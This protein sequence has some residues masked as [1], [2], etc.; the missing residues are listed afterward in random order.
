MKAVFKTDS[1]RGFITATIVPANR[2]R[3]PRFNL[4]DGLMLVALVGGIAA[5]VRLVLAN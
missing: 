2:S 5:L 1:Q 3:E 4:A